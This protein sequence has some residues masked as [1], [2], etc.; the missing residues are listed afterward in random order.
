[1]N[2]PKCNAV[3][4]D[5]SDTCKNC[6]YTLSSN[7]TPAEY[8]EAM[9][10]ALDDAV[11]QDI[12]DSMD[13]IIGDTINEAVD[14][15]EIK[16]ED[17]DKF[18]SELAAQAVNDNSSAEKAKITK[19]MDPTKKKLITIVTI[20]AVAIL[21]VIIIFISVIV[22]VFSSGSNEANSGKYMAVSGNTVYFAN[23]LDGNKLYKLDMNKDEAEK[24]C[25]DSVQ[26]ISVAGNTIYYTL[27]RNDEKLCSITVDG[28]NSN[29]EITEHPA[30]YVT[31]ADGYV[32]YS[33]PGENNQIYRVTSN[34]VVETIPDALGTDIQ[35]ADG[36]LYYINNGTLTSM[37]LSNGNT[38]EYATNVTK[39]DTDGQTLSF[40]SNDTISFYK[41]A[42]KNGTNEGYTTKVTTATDLEVVKEG[43][44]FAYLD[45]DGIVKHINISSDSTTELSIEG[46]DELLYTGKK[47][48]FIDIDGQRLAIS[49][50]SGEAN[51]VHLPAGE[52]YDDVPTPMGNQVNDGYGTADKNYLYYLDYQAQSI[53]KESITDQNDSEILAEVPASNLTVSEGWL[54]YADYSVGGMIYKMRTDGTEATRISIDSATNMIVY[55]D[56]IYYITYNSDLG[57][58]Y[59][60]RTTRDGQTT[61]TLKTGAIANMT[62]ADGWI[63]YTA[64]DQEQNSL[65]LCR[66]FTNGQYDSVLIEHVGQAV[67]AYEDRI[68]YVE[69]DY[70]H[71]KSCDLTGQDIQDIGDKS[72]QSFTIQDDTIYFSELENNNPLYKMNLDGSD[73]TMLTDTPSFGLSACGDTIIFASFDETSQTYFI[74]AIKTDGTGERKVG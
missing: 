40:I 1:M 6:G 36:Y 64:V 47:Y 28:K 38:V 73:E 55:G 52:Q 71:L 3:I 18:Q 19:T 50:G 49:S 2:C 12:P 14:D 25:E 20:A 44:E 24:I 5:G 23:P 21:A 22:N 16:E 67:A 58:Y 61:N 26:Y 8:D 27:P 65:S 56:W 51:E 9:H 15:E 4:P 17:Y 39:F 33:N 37:D 43:H 10:Q 32:Y 30:R 57:E 13:E 48:L 70:A 69:G 7:D 46:Y 29:K 34:G 59:I 53:I 31:F 62:I 11:E 42:A 74:C 45:P 68:Y 54:Y 66:M 41:N 72:V 35:V 60:R 63:Y